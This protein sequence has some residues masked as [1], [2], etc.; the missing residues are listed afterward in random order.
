MLKS[1]LEVNSN[2]LVIFLIFLKQKT[3]KNMYVKIECQNSIVRLSFL[4]H[5]MDIKMAWISPYYCDDTTL[6][7]KG[8]GFW[9]WIWPTR[10]CRLGQEL[11]CWFWCQKNMKMD[12]SFFE[13][14]ISFKMLGL[15][16]SFKL[17]WGSYTV[18]VAK[19]VSKKIE[20][21]FCS[22]KFF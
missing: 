6:Y 12:G 19:T 14:K 4:C 7:S 18:P 21:S 11:A 3:N 13:E 15:S 1:L 2:S 20:A 8:V 10:H 16:C 22:M 17:D 9:T 5:I